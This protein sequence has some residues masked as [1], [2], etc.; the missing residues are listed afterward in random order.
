[1]S[2]NVQTLI[3]G[4]FLIKTSEVYQCFISYHILRLLDQWR[5]LILETNVKFQMKNAEDLCIMTLKSGAKFEE[6]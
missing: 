5:A 4:N 2:S 3:K 1:M 6:K